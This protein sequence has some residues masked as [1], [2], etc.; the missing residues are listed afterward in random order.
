M[1][2]KQTVKINEYL[3]GMREGNISLLSDLY[4]CT[5]QQLYTVCFSYFRNKAEAEDAVSE[6]YLRVIEKINLFNGESGITWLCTIAR[7]ICL[8]ILKR[9]EKTVAVDFED[10]ATQAVLDLPYEDM[11]DNIGNDAIQELIRQILT[12]YELRVVLFHVMSDMKFREIAE[13]E[14][15]PEATV[16]WAYNNALGK[17]RKEA[18]R[19]GIK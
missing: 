14:K 8:N 3:S 9:N 15:R 4:D 6:T 17:I 12:P 16:R 13:I 19:R 11:T 7:N 18:G 5:S 10:E 2:K 1:P